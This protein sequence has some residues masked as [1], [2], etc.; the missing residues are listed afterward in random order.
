MNAHEFLCGS[1][2]L[3]EGQFRE[4]RATI[5]GE[6]RYLILTRHQDA[7]RAWLNVCPHQGRPLNWAPDQFLTDGNG[8][9]VCAAHG[10]V[11]E[12]DQGRCVSGPCRNASLTAVEIEEREGFVRLK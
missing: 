3:D 9:L 5:D 6:V 2:D 7:V 11:F 4:S 12:C 1:T 10:A 8:N